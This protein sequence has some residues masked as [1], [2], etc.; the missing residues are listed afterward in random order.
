MV[1]LLYFCFLK[2]HAGE[3]AGDGAQMRT[4][5]N[6]CSRLR[7]EDLEARATA[8]RNIRPTAA[9]TGSAQMLKPTHWCR[10]PNG[11]PVMRP[12]HLRG[13]A[14]S[15][16]T[17]WDCRSQRETSIRLQGRRSRS[18]APR[19]IGVGAL[20]A[21]AGVGK[22]TVAQTS[23]A[24]YRESVT[25]PPHF[26]DERRRHIINALDVGLQYSNR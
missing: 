2:T 14:S 21:D 15:C 9:R 1:L 22:P 8:S 5:V 24:S 6:D 3:T 4:E 17:Y 13:L 23:G 12:I 25:L 16:F 11:N 10:E 18:S 20:L 26:R 7:K 19:S